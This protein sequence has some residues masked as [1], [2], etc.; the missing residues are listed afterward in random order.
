MK[1]VLPG[2]QVGCVVSIKGL[3]QL[4]TNVDSGVFKV[5]QACAI[6]VYS[7]TTKVEF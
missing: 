3:A 4:K 5:I 7:P 2:W 6:A 1:Q